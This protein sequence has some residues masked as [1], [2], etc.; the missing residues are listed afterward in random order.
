MMAFINVLDEQTINQIAAGEVVERPLNVVKELTENALDSGADSITVEIKDGGSK[1]IRVTDNGCGLSESE[2]RKAFLRHATSKIVCADDLL[3]ITSLGFRGEA[4][5]SICAVSSVEMISKEKDKIVGFRYLIEGSEEISLE[6]IGA[7]DGTTVIVKDL[8]FNTP[9]RKKFLKSNISEA[10]MVSN[11]MEHLSLS[12]PDVSIKYV[13]NGKTIF[14]TSGNGDIKEVIY[15]IYGKEIKDKLIPIDI[16]KDYVSVHGFI[17]KPEINRGQRSCENFF[18]NGRYIF[19]DDLSKALEEGYRNFMMQHKFPFCVLYMNVEPS[20]IDVNVHPSKMEIRL[21]NRELICEDLTLA[22]RSL[23]A[24]VSL[25]PEA[26]L[27]PEEEEKV[28]ETVPEPFE[29]KRKEA[30]FYEYQ[31]KTIKPLEIPKVELDE[32]SSIIKASEQVVIKDVSQ[33]NVF[34]DDF[35]TPK[36]RKDYHILGQIFKTYWLIEFEEKLYIMD[37]HAAHEK[38]RYERLLKHFR[39]KDIISQP[40]VPPLIFDITMKEAAIIK[41]YL[42]AFNKMGFE[43]E[44]FGSGSVAVRSFPVDLYGCNERTF[45]REILDEISENPLKGDYEV[46]LNKL[47]S[48]ACKAAVKGNMDMSETEVKALLDEL[49]SLDNPYNCPHGRPT[50]ISMSKYEIEK[51]FK[52]IVD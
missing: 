8:F 48:M 25:I 47:A 31:P 21:Q 27:V 9:A 12:H 3:N 20:A 28:V 38:V 4:L 50:I 32:G 29:T 13:V 22:V 39:D 10:G 15:R 30:F 18:I 2:V 17:A 11:L 1:L 14:S 49:L 36:A 37:Q 34:D 16:Q 26:V 46:I 51:K 52:R 35:L 33:I 23:L 24:N 5:S 19:S 42:F 45:F 43:I 6:E 40:L 41:E 7:P 44:D